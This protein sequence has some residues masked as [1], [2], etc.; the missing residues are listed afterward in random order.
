MKLKK[1][2]LILAS[3]TFIT[4]CSSINSEIYINSKSDTIIT[5]ST[6]K[7]KHVNKKRST[8]K[9]KKKSTKKSKKKKSSKKKKNKYKTIDKFI[10]LYEKKYNTSITDVQK[11]DIKGEDYRTEFRLGAF[12]NAIGKKGYINGYKIE[13][14]NYGSWSRDSFRIYLTADSN[15]NA[16]IMF[17]QLIKIFD[18]TISD[19]DIDETSGTVSKSEI[20]SQIIGYDIFISTT[21]IKF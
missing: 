15:E 18:N 12:D 16:L 7:K 11:M 19:D 2:L 10:S 21:K 8:K 13:M 9:K 14:V 1:I 6:N 3:L 17:K 20:S 5:S 4:A